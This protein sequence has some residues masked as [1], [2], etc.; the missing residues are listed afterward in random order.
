M[1]ALATWIEK[2]KPM[3]DENY[4]YVC[5]ACLLLWGVVCFVGA[6]LAGRGR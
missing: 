6:W 3:P 5:L 1:I 4:G 2:P